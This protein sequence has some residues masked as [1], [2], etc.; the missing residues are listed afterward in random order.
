M[1]D[2]LWTI[3]NVLSLLR[4]ILV[5][6]VWL[7]LRSDAEEARLAALGLMVAA[8]ATDLL[9]GWLARKLG[10]VTET[11][12]ILDPLADKLAIGVVC[13][14]LAAR[15]IVPAWFFL[16]VIVRDVLILLGGIYV[17]KT[18]GLLLQSNYPGKW[19]AAAVTVYLVERVALSGDPGGI[20]AALLIIASVMLAVSFVLYLGR[21]T[22]ICRKPVS[23]R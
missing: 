6:P 19:A 20:G 1:S 8:A 5:L 12:K 16:A 15:G 11:G 21:F 9:D 10:Q 14:A 3:S 18:R 7:L 13:A 4:L 17:R 2:R 22:S 23:A